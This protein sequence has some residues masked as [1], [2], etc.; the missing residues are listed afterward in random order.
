MWKNASENSF[1]WYFDATGSIHKTV[2]KQQKPF[3]YSLVFHDNIHRS[4]IPIAEFITT[5][6]DQT[7]ISDQF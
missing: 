3:Y 6:Q 5:A 7:N 1:V 2:N 4:I